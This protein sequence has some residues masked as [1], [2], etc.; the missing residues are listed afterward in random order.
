VVYAPNYRET[1]NQVVLLALRASDG[2]A[3][4]EHT[5]VGGIQ[6]APVVD[7]ALVFL[8][9]SGSQQGGPG[10]VEALRT[11]DG[12]DAWSTQVGAAPSGVVI[13]DGLVILSSGGAVSALQEKTGALA[14][15]T[16]GPP[17]QTASG[18]SLYAPT[19]AGNTVYVEGESGLSVD[20]NRFALFALDAKTGAHL[21][22]VSVGVTAYEPLIVGATAIVSTSVFVNS[23]DSSTVEGLDVANG[24][25]LWSYAPPPDFV[26]SPP[27]LAQGNIYLT[28]A[29]VSHAADIANGSV[30][31][32]R[33]SDGAVQWR[34][35]VGGLA[36]G[37]GWSPLLLGESQLCVFLNP[38]TATAPGLTVALNVSGGAIRWQKSLSTILGN[39]LVIHNISYTLTNSEQYPAGVVY[40]VDLSDSATVWQYHT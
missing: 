6:S 9:S 35:K 29:G 20:T 5:V 16:N 27:V 32:L 38:T 34:T 4:W 37:A 33:V 12:S 13:A 3:L 18:N 39:S 36:F 23:T 1:T 7:G 21:W 14:W 17:V 2:A 15:T 40:A 10:R 24:S 26:L 8:T 11:R 31:A 19:V 30:V 28:Q 22:S 25:T